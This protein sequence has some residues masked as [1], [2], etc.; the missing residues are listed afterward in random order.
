MRDCEYTTTSGP[1][2]VVHLKVAS[3]QE[4]VLKLSL[5]VTAIR[6]TGKTVIGPLGE[7]IPELQYEI[8]VGTSTA[9]KTS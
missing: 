2:T 7:V 4:Y 9:K 6:E 5:S 8:N 1:P 3:G